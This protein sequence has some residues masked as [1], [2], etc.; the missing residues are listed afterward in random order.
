[1]N[2]D[3]GLRTRPGFSA[4]ALAAAVLLG[5]LCRA[6]SL[7]PRFVWVYPPTGNIIRVT[8][9]A[10]PGGDG[11]FLKPMD[12]FTAFGPGSP[13]KPGDTI[14][15]GE[16]VY[17]GRIAGT[18]RAPFEL[19]VCGEAGRPILVMPYPGAR[20][21]LNGSL[22]VSGS[23][24]WCF[25]LEVGDLLWDPSLRSHSAPPALAAVSGTGIKAI[26]C[27]LFGG[28]M[29]ATLWNQA[30][31][32]EVYGCLVHD[33][34]AFTGDAMSGQGHGFFV[35]NTDGKKTLQHNV[36]YRG[37]GANLF[38]SSQSTAIKGIEIRENVF[39]MPG[40]AAPG[41]AQENCFAAGFLPIDEISL[42]GNLFYMPTTQH[43]RHVNARFR[44]LRPV[45]NG[46]GAIADNYFAGGQVGLSLGAW[47]QLAVS[48]NTIWAWL[49]NVELSSWPT[50]SSLP[51][52]ADLP[53][54]AGYSI[55]N[56]K[57]ID[58]ARERV[59]SYG[60]S[61]RT[62]Q[63]EWM[64]WPRWREVGFDAD[65]VMLPGV[66]GR[67]AGSKTFVFPNKY[68]ANA[69]VVAV[70]NWDGLDEVPV[71]LA[72]ALRRGVRF[73]ARN[74]LDIRTTIS[75]AEPVFSGLHNGRAF[76]LPMRKDPSSPE[77]EVFIVSAD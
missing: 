23:H 72:A 60:S 21:H 55:N 13:A 77:F 58:N 76:F 28:T 56:N 45:F 39:F 68:Q 27:N 73:S 32:L 2:N 37:F 67:P 18:R 9:D 74:C 24:V 50:A 14:A 51:T 42:T 66:E 38:V 70:F 35:Q 63:E 53:D 52:A 12:V 20:V 30:R 17:E 40:A 4:A 54:P 5:G 62:R 61:E 65:S 15:L 11:S 33:F 44:T 64:S 57:Y 3:T 71:D 25:N 31:N 26:N 34:G 1:M 6:Q 7:K 48:G 49:I 59:F 47:R 22:A 8:A 19:A 69:A 75:S 36:V 29:G 41:M 46:G 10:A 43:T 16:G